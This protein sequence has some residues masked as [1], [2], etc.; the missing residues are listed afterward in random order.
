MVWGKVW[1]EMKGA[2][3]LPYRTCRKKKCAAPIA[4]ITPLKMAALPRQRPAWVLRAPLPR[5]R[6]SGRGCGRKW[7]R[8][9]TRPHMWGPSGRKRESV[10]VCEK[11][12]KLYSL[13]SKGQTL[14]SNN[15]STGVTAGFFPS[16][17][18]EIQS[19]FFHVLSITFFFSFFSVYT[20]MSPFTNLFPLYFLIPC[21]V[22]SSFCV[23]FPPQVSYHVRTYIYIYIYICIHIYIYIYIGIGRGGG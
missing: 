5:C 23:R 13:F 8:E 18:W 11:R 7:H 9:L 21:F 6:C 15:G 17:L 20:Q 2:R 12:I 1:S 3:G 10:C 22:Y 19:L 14:R 4:C 16:R